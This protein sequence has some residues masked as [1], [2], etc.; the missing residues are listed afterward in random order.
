MADFNRRSALAGAVGLALAIGARAEAGEPAIVFDALGETRPPYDM[1]LVDPISAS[2][3]RGVAVNVIGLEHGCIGSDRVHRVP[4]DAARE[5]R[6]LPRQ[7][8]SQTEPHDWPLHFERLN[9]PNRMTV[10]RQEL[11]RRGMAAVDIDKIMG[12]NLVR[13]Y[14]EVVG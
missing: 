5:R 10:I 8:G 3:T 14:R 1:A 13:P 2:G 12:G 4:L 9:G 11:G 6:I 7:E